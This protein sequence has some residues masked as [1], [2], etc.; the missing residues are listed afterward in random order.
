MP[1]LFTMLMVPPDMLNTLVGN[2]EV[3]PSEGDVVQ[4][5]A[6]QMFNTPLRSI[7]N[8]TGFVDVSRPATLTVPPSTMNAAPSPAPLVW[9][10]PVPILTPPAVPRTNPLLVGEPF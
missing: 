1:R 3:N 6:V 10:P 2:V 7:T 5:P 8:V 4:P 9:G